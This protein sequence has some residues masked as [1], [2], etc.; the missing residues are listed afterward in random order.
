MRPIWNITYRIRWFYYKVLMFT[1]ALALGNCCSSVGQARR[2]S[3]LSA[4]WEHISDLLS[5]FRSQN[6]PLIVTS[7]M[8]RDIGDRTLLS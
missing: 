6:L 7:V 4:S 5:S 2:H 1:I 3:C 8:L